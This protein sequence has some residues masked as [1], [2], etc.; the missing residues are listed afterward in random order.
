LTIAPDDLDQAKTST[1]R[2][3]SRTSNASETYGTWANSF[4]LKENDIIGDQEDGDNLILEE[5]ESSSYNKAQSC[6]AKFE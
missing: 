3:S 1:K 2:S 4:L 5:K 6:E